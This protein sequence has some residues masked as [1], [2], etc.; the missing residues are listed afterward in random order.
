MRKMMIAI[1]LV[2]FGAGCED[3]TPPK[4]TKAP[5][6]PPVVKKTPPVPMVKEVKPQLPTPEEKPKPP[7]AV[8]PAGKNPPAASAVP[9]LLL[10]PSL[11][12]WSQTAPA[13]FKAKFSTSKGDF[14]ALVK[15]EWAPKGADRFYCLVKNGYFDDVRFFRVVEGFMAQFGINGAPEVNAAWK[16]TTIPDDPVVE[17]N[18]RGM[19]SFAM[20]GPNTRT[21]QIFISYDDKNTRLDAMNFAPFAKVVEGM[22]VVDKLYNGYGEG[23]PRGRGPDQGRVQAEGNAYLNSDFKELDFVKSARIVP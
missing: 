11:P 3:E 9:K 8:E 13:E 5:E 12:E 22:D 20:R 7:P 6:P 4:R 16:N 15:R 14:T 1:L 17:S 21:V 2:S 19:I 18:K 10:D 23:A